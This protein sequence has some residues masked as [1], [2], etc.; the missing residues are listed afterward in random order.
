M[1]SSR[2]LE[3]LSDCCANSSA[4]I[5]TASGVHQQPSEKRQR[6]NQLAREMLVAFLLSFGNFCKAIRI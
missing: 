4:A 5:C 6:F 2:E 3:N 1:R